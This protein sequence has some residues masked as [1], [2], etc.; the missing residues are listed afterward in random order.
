MLI[1]EEIGKEILLNMMTKGN[2]KRG[3]EES[4]DG[5]KD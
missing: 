5:R 2:R 4:L 3:L 1:Y